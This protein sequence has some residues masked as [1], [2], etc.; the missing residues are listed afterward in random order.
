MRRLCTLGW[1]LVVGLTPLHAQTVS[2]GTYGMVGGGIDTTVT[3][4]ATHFTFPMSWPG[5]GIVDTGYVVLG[6][7]DGRAMSLHLTLRSSAEASAVRQHWNGV[8][9]GGN[10]TTA[11]TGTL[12]QFTDS[13]GA[14][15]YGYVH[16]SHDGSV[17]FLPGHSLRFKLLKNP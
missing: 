1:L 2:A 4:K 13:T 10:T 8:L 11:E 5:V 17:Y 3:R 9:R 12:Y 15:S 16:A 14:T 7:S 6:G